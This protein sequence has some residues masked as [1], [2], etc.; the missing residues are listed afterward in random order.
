MGF[1]KE[2]KIRTF[3]PNDDSL[4]VTF[5]IGGYDVKKV[6]VD[7]GSGAEIMYWGLYKG[8]D[9]KPKDLGKYDSLL[10]GFDKRNVIPC[11]MIKLHV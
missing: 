3:Q 7:Q 1:S 5:R 2:D 6:L 11:G 4:I 10:V 9:L 8:L